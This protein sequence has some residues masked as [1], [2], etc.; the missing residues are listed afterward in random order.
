M[1]WTV[2]NKL[3]DELMAIAGEEP[4]GSYVTFLGRDPVFP[5]PL[6][7]GE[8]GAATVAAAAVEAA[9]LWE[10]KTG[11]SQSVAVDIDAAA[12]G[13]RASR[14]IRRED[15]DSEEP[16]AGNRQITAGRGGGLPI[17]QDRNGRW[18]YFQR[19]FQNHR[20]IT[21]AILQCEYENEA[22][23]RAVSKWDAF[24]LENAVVAG[25]ATA[26]VV[27][28]YDEWAQ[29]PQAQALAKLPLFDIVRVADGPPEPLPAG[30]RPLIGIR[31]VD[32]TRVISGP[33]AAR[34]LAEHGATVLHVGHSRLP[35]NPSQYLDGGHG[36]RAAEVD[37][38]T[39]EG[40]GT[41]RRLIA[42]ADVFS[43]SIRPGSLAAR[44]F[45]AE[46]LVELRPGLI[47][48]S[49]SAFG[50]EGPWSLRRGF[51]SIVQACSGICNELATD[52]RPRFAPANPLDY[53]T[54]YIAA[55]GVMAALKRRALE[56]GSYHVRVSLAQ[57]G[58]WLTSQSRAPAEEFAGKPND[59]SPERLRGLMIT[60]DTPAGRL[61]Y[62]APIAVMSETPPGW[63]LP[64]APIGQH[65][66]QW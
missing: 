58:R 49:L 39:P 62:L 20:D 7:I 65:P 16:L 54:G 51:D 60:R 9:R 53:A 2:P 6:R 33:T 61:S 14:Y 55:F 32:Q 8:V 40:A 22:L 34:T 24:E 30:D 38:D 48:L 42:G 57:T 37:I 11:R 1:E 66:P 52:G 31:V 5:T 23:A 28:S 41:L 47:M 21:A 63:D 17:F 12:A 59:L 46:R 3:L 35:E 27:R 56:G 15:K 45:S 13:M 26:G 44:G 18:I 4:A 29:H 10:L 64:T 50:H 19:E 43:Q 36:K 25:G